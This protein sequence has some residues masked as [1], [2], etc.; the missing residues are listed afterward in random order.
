MGVIGAMNFAALDLNLLRVFDAMAIE[1][2]TTRTGE[3]VGLSQPAVSSALGRLRQ[4]LGDE[5]FVREGNRMVPTERALALRERSLGPDDPAVGI[6]LDHIGAQLLH[7]HRYEEALARFRRAYAIRVKRLGP[8]HPDLAYSLHDIGSALLGEHHYEQALASL[9]RSVALREAKL[10]KEHPGLVAPLSL[11]GQAY[12]ALGSTDRALEVLERGVA[13]ALGGQ[14]NLEP[15]TCAEVRFQ[16][17][18][19][20]EAAHRDPARALALASEARRIYESAGPAFA[21]DVAAVD[22]WLAPRRR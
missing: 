17:A 8:E 11:E 14:S 4:I 15:A 6:V 12:L 19:A 16:L 5:L 9:R 20:L 3:R 2:N 21:D 1:L 18:R 10:G 13:L 22:R 7:L